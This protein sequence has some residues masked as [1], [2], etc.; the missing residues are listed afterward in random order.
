MKI[1]QG[2]RANFSLD[3]EDLNTETFVCDLAEACEKDYP[4]GVNNKM[5]YLLGMIE[6]R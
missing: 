1:I 5:S 6:E 2:N 3:P 4:T